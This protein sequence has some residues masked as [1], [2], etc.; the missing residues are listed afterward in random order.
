MPICNNCYTSN[1]LGSKSCKKCG[2]VL[3]ANEGYPCPNCLGEN[4]PFAQQCKYCGCNLNNQKNENIYQNKKVVTSFV[5]PKKA[6]INNYSKNKVHSID[7]IYLSKKK[8]NRN[9]R[10]PFFKDLKKFN[11]IIIIFALSIGIVLL[12]IF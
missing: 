5:K 2:R 12:I 8:R 10:E 6:Q 11:W 7:T 4:G 1:P 9:L 3:P